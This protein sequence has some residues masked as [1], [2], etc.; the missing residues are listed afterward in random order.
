MNDEYAPPAEHPEQNEPDPAPIERE[1]EPTAKPA[2]SPRLALPVSLL[3]TIVS[4]FA[5]RYAF[6]PDQA[7]TWGM[8]LVLFAVYAPCAAVAIVL[9]RREGMLA[10]ELKPR[11][12]DLTFGALIAGVMY[13]AGMGARQF[14][15]SA[16][17]PRNWWV[18]RLYLQLGD[19]ANNRMLYVGMAVFVIAVLEELTWRGLVMRSLR[20]AFGPLRAWLLSSVL[21]A[22]SH[23][24]TISLLAHPVAG[25]N[26]LLVA[27]AL[28]CGLVWGHLYNRA[29][30]LLPCLFAHGLFSMAIVDFPLWRP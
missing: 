27:A 7:G 14:L 30:R 25:P 23:V 10:E 15:L 26:P 22:V 11:N 19:T 8:L 18:V 4:A 3:V 29:G 2:L 20:Q 28:G 9:M 1:S 21:Y 17:S 24:A 13:V 16:D 12:G 5:L 6:H